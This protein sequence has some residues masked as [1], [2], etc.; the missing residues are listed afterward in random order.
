MPKVKSQPS[1]FT[2][3]ELLIVV[4]VIGILAAITIVW[5]TGVSQKAIASSLQSDLTNGSNKLKLYQVENGSY[6][7]SFTDG[8]GGNYCPDP[9]DT[10]YCIK[11]SPGTTFTYSPEVGSS[12]QNFTLDAIY[13]S[14]STTYRMTSNTPPVLVE[15]EVV[16]VPG[17][18]TGLFAT[19]DC[20]SSPNI[21]FVTLRWV[22]P[23]D[24]GGSV[25]TNYKVYRGNTYGQ[26]TPLIVLSNVLTYL[27]SPVSYWHTYYYKV[28]AI[29]AIGEG[30]YGN[31]V[32]VYT[33]R[34]YQ[35]P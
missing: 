2:I 21:S 11:A 1:G 8:G 5:Y 24:D 31:E 10:R 6:P 23:V 32:S 27:N 13:T 14:S 18:P 9:P 29:N 16:I 15:E 35:A 22:A 25:I 17:P 19:P 12:P 30:V 20:T 28:T 33:P 34:C 3:V 4:V 26:E 7:T